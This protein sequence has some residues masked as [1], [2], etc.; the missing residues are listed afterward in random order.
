HTSINKRD[1][2]GR[3]I[4]ALRSVYI[5]EPERR[6]NQYPLELSGGMRQRVMI[7]MALVLEP[8]VLIA[9]EPTTALDVTIQAEILHILAEIR[10]QH[11]TSIILITHD[12]GVVAETADRVII[13]RNGQLVEDGDVY[14]IFDR[15][16]QTYTREL[17]AAVPVF[18]QQPEAHHAGVTA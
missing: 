15:P 17:L 11:N 12:M 1:A 5:P 14:G 10:R 3:A 2:R 7:A 18:G 4:D 9:D 6:L 13:L 8:D 16:K